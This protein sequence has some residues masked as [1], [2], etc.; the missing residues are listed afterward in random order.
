MAPRRAFSY[1]LA[2]GTLEHEVTVQILST[3]Q[4]ATASACES[5]HDVRVSL[6]ADA[7]CHSSEASQCCH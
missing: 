1:R 6:H 4:P 7:F 3:Q 5:Q 2:D